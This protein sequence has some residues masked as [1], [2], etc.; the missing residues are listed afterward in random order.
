MPYPA[1]IPPAVGA[2]NTASKALLPGEWAKRNPLLE[3]WIVIEIKYDFN[4]LL[5]KDNWTYIYHIYN[6][7]N[8]LVKKAT[9]GK[10]EI[11]S[12]LLGANKEAARKGKQ[13]AAA[14]KKISDFLLKTFRG[15]N[16]NAGDDEEIGALVDIPIEPKYLNQ[17]NYNP[18][19][20]RATRSPSLWYMANMGRDFDQKARYFSKSDFNTFAYEE[21]YILPLGRIYQTETTGKNLNKKFLEA[22]AGKK[23]LTDEEITSML[24]AGTGLFG[25][26]F[27]Y[28][29]TTISY[30]NSVDTS[31]DW[32]LNQQDP[33]RFFGGNMTISFDL[34]LNRIADL[35]SLQKISGTV[36]I[37]P[38]DYPGFPI[39][40]DVADNLYYRG[41][42]YDI[43]YLY[44]TIN[45][46]PVP[47]SLTTRGLA[48]SDF[49]YITGSPVWIHLHNNL[50]FKGSLVSM[51]VTH[52]S[53]SDRMVPMLSVVNLSF[54]RYPELEGIGG[55]AEAKDALA[56]RNIIAGTTGE[57]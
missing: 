38:E 4:L 29:P 16:P 30:N 35:A 40:P 46:S 22:Q 2:I 5:F 31:I 54:I 13:Y 47:T 1:T 45:G 12:G 50:R 6:D 34:Y 39:S 44:R 52:V 19:P 56:K 55:K 41:T 36:Y 21:K 24:K 10:D 18:P 26:R 33:S 14:L 3:R 53:F 42:E 28:N 37:D 17:I 11:T 9:I 23:S 48:T 7:D 51:N 27:L 20:H 15:D 49:G 25:F 8:T 32:I 43:E 57:G